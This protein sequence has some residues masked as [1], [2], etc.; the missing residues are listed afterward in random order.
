MAPTRRPTAKSVRAAKLLERANHYHDENSMDVDED[1]EPQVKLKSSDGK[2]FTLT[3]T[4]A[5]FSNT[6][7]M[8][9]ESYQTEQNVSSEVI[10]LRIHSDMLA[11]VVCWC[12]MHCS[13]ESQDQEEQTEEDKAFISSLSEEDLFRL[14]HVANYLNIKSLL[15]ACCRKIAI[16]W[17]GKKVEE[18]RKMYL[19]ENDFPPEE[20]NQML[21]ES[22]K[23]GMDDWSSSSD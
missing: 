23:L 5:S 16:K 9:I 18:I 6:L 15:D 20:E 21:I 17:E 13:D 2:R 10:S 22:K 14:T 11:K 1:S 8:M 12:Q 4:E 7:R 19:I 3:K